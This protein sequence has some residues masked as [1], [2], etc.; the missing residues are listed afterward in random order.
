MIKLLKKVNLC[1]KMGR[2]LEQ[3]SK[4]FNER[5]ELSITVY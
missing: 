2:K 3:L 4:Y 5:L 1:Y